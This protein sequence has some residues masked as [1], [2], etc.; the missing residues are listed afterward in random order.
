MHSTFNHNEDLP[1]K[2]IGLSTGRVGF[3]LSLDPTCRRR[4]EGGGTRNRPPAS[5]G[6]V[7]FGFGWCLGRF[8]WWRESPDPANVAGIFKKFTEICK[9]PVDLHQK[10]PKLAWISSNLA[11]SHQIWSRSRLDL[12]K[13]RRISPN[14]AWIS[15]NVAGSHQISLECR[16]I[17]PDFA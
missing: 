2:E 8:D 5:L 1:Y 15:S 13:C 12:L 6:R 3:R 16:R 4:V 7:G 17:L 10:S 9:N 14:L 11:G